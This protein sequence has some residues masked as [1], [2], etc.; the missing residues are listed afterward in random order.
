MSETI[1]FH[2]HEATT[3]Q[4]KAIEAVIL[5]GRPFTVDQLELVA[6]GAGLARKIGAS[7]ESKSPAR[8]FAK[9]MINKFRHRIKNLPNHRMIVKT[10]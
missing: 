5:S 10:Q 9:Y 8:I 6:V 4:Y 1:K 2:G 7:R 3:D